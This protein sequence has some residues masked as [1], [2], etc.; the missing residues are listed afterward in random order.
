MSRAGA[1][2]VR[3]ELLRAAVT[4]DATGG[5]V[6]TWSPIATVWAERVQS[7]VAE[8]IAAGQAQASVATLFR[9]RWASAW[10]DLDPT[11][12]VRERDSRRTYDVRGVVEPHQVRGAS[13]RPRTWLEI[14][15]VARGERV[16]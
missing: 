12:R 16:A 3:L 2:N 4:T 10:A 1:L 14:S 7:S 9:I 13:V 15:A 11:D 6:Q 8:R 5:E